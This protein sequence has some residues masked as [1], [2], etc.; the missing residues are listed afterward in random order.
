MTLLDGLF[1]NKYLFSLK[2]NSGKIRILGD[3]ESKYNMGFQNLQ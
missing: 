1:A 3:L 2:S